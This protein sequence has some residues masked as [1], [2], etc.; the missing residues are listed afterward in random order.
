MRSQIQGPGHRDS[1]EPWTATIRSTHNAQTWTARV[2]IGIQPTPRQIGGSRVRLHCGVSLV[3]TAHGLLT[4]IPRG[5]TGPGARDR[6]KGAGWPCGGTGVCPR[7]VRPGARVFRRDPRRAAGHRRG[8]RRVVRGPPGGGPVGR[9][10]RL[11]A[12]PA[13]G[14]GQRGPAVFGQQADRGGVR[15]AAGPGRAAQVGRAGA[16]VLARVPRSGDGTSGAVA[17]GRGGDAGPAGAHRGV[18]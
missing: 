16:A 15:A 4:A 10:R 17:S 12:A 11:R 9:L 8:V 2:F 1:P 5:R 18:L 3:V 13:V 14:R 7:A 6:R